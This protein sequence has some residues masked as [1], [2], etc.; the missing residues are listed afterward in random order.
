MGV[1][2]DKFIKFDDHITD[3]CRSTHFHIRNIGN[4]RNLYDACSTVIMHLLVIMYM[5]KLLYVENDWDGEVDC[6]EVKEP[7][8]LISEEDVASAIKG[9]KMAK[10]AGPTGVVSEM[11][12]ASGG[13]GSRWMTDLINNIVKVGCI[14]DDWRKS[15]LLLLFAMIRSVVKSFKVPDVAVVSARV[16]NESALTHMTDSTPKKLG[17]TCAG[18]GWRS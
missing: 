18:P 6:P 1:I 2:L 15:I 5:E 4:I 10:A 17:K 12:K 7:C 16:N 9:L 3:I 8:C 14:P 11:M 13:F